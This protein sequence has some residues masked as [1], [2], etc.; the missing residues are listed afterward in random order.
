MVRVRNQLGILYACIVLLSLSGNS[1]A[2]AQLG[3]PA[4][5]DAGQ[6]AQ[7][8]EDSLK[9][10]KVLDKQKQIK[11]NKDET[12]I[13]VKNK[14]QQSSENKNTIEVKQLNIKGN[15]ILPHQKFEPVL[16]K[17]EG[18]TLTLDELNQVARE[19]QNIYHQHG[20]K[21]TQ[22]FI[23]PQD[24][25]NGI[26]VIQVSEG[27][28]GVVAI[29]G[30]HAYRASIIKYQVKELKRGEPLDVVTLEDTLSTVN[31]NNNFKLKAIL[32]AGSKNGETDVTLNVYEPQPW[33]L[34]PSF[35]N[36]GRPNV[37]TM[38]WGAGLTN[39]SLLGF[40]D[41]LSLKYIGAS[42]TQVA[43][44]GYN[45]PVS[46]W[47]TRLGYSYSFSHVDVN[48][49]LPNPPKIEGFA[50]NHSLTLSQ[51]LDKKR[52]WN[53][54]ASFNAKRITSNIN[55]FQLNQDDIRSLTFGL[56]F[57]KFDRTGRTVGRISTDIAP[58]WMSSNREFWKGNASLTRV[59]SL[60]WGMT[61]IARAS[62]Q[63]SPDALPSAETIQIGGAHSVRGFSEGLL[64]GDR[65]YNL[66]TEV[67]YPIP[68]LKHVSPWLG[69]RIHG[70]AFFDMG[71]V[72]FDKSNPNYIKGV[73]HTSK[74][75]MLMSAG[76]GVRAQ[77]TRFLIGFVDFGYG[78]TNQ[79]NIEPNAQPTVRV[80]F[81]LRSDLLSKK[82]KK[83]GNV[84]TII[85]Q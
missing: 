77:I 66:S 44:A 30:N 55:N 36:Q 70:A 28:I 40:G 8:E 6:I 17:Y 76:L 82:L 47:G 15:G 33:Q 75:T 23:P 62:G 72:W 4:Q 64:S 59:Q 25:E 73:S 34:S 3:L 57:N 79:G 78:I 29:E 51:P 84:K 50:N 27:K 37:G 56:N 63:L 49:N 68:G 61:L 9:S 10:N 11:E 54:D 48:L 32:E 71:Q 60:P 65:G 80:H 38:R 31:Q 16:K 53:I 35:D 24:V 52:V 12:S 67:R 81:G 74:R 45:I 18:K 26:V 5:I 19:V 22:V 21:T 58:Q 14:N 42:G 43:A 41:E 1:S 13:E 2:Y 85:S 39:D 46:K 69:N 83:R 7:P 20:Y